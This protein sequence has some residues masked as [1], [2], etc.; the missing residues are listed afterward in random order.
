[1]ASSSTPDDAMRRCASTPSTFF[2]VEGQ[3]LVTAFEQIASE[4]TKL[5]LTQ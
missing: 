5:K 4:I 2:D 1:M 3:D